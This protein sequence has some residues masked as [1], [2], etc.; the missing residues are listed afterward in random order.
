MLISSCLLWFMVF[1]F[2]GWIYESIYCTLKSGTWEN[3]G[4]LFGPIC[5]IYGTGA[6]LIFLIFGIFKWQGGIDAPYWKIFLICFIG[7]AILEYTTSYLLEKC[8]HALWWDY[9]DMPLQL[10]GRICLPASLV[11]GG[12]GTILVKFLLSPILTLDQMI[13]PIFKEGIALALMAYLSAD[14][15][16][17]IANLTELLATVQNIENEFNQRAE[18]TYQLAGETK[19]ALEQKMVAY[20]KIISEKL[21]DYSR[22][23][24]GYQRNLL[25]RIARFKRTN[26][27]DIASRLKD[28]LSLPWKN[29]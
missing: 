5:P 1:S 13:L 21:K 6:I 18:A 15:V 23:L 26:P 12:S 9:S 10:H 20:E 28:A 27:L 14:L 3:R 2:L 7:S 16:L 11:F 17:T 19:Q 25:R 24:N 29:K 4:F 22:Q 8:F